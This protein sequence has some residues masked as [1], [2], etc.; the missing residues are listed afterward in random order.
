MVQT[1]PEARVEPTPPN[2]QIYTENKNRIAL[3]LAKRESFL[4]RILKAPA[5]TSQ[6]QGEG[7][8]QAKHKPQA[9][10][11]DLDYELD[12]LQGP[13]DFNTGLGYR[14]APNAQPQ[15]FLSRGV[16]GTQL[17]SAGFKALKKA[18]DVKINGG[19]RKAYP[20]QNRSSKRERGAESSDEDEGR[21]ALGRRKKSRRVED[22]L[23]AGSEILN[24]T[25]LQNE[26][27]EV[28]GEAVEE[29]AEG[30]TLE[31]QHGATEAINGAEATVVQDFVE[32]R[33]DWEGITDGVEAARDLD[34]VVKYAAGEISDRQ[35]KAPTAVDGATAAKR[36]KGK[37]NKKKRNR[38]KRT[39]L[40]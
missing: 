25:R 26:V 5:K 21:T 14:S 11:Q 32:E 3:S 31:A 7:Q 40:N 1:Q 33:G 28:S 9:E 35:S 38:Q 17:P 10:P 24:E 23:E 18:H 27:A 29:T 20:T 30:A 15:T 8:S 22:V 6:D 34:A 19:P 2:K 12:F 16:S 37:K 36:K 39:T 4:A 13:L